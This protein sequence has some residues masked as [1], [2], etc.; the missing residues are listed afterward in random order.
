MALP[1]VHMPFEVQIPIR[2]IQRSAPWH[3][4]SSTTFEGERSMYHSFTQHLTKLHSKSLCWSWRYCMIVDSPGPCSFIFSVVSPSY[5]PVYNW[6]SA[7]YFIPERAV[8]TKATL[9]LLAIVS[10]SYASYLSV[11]CHKS[12]WSKGRDMVTSSRQGYCPVLALSAMRIYVA[13][14]IINNNSKSSRK[15]TSVRSQITHCSEKL[16]LRA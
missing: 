6:V 3:A 12:G 8:G 2:D 9:F 16:S 4:L 7:W 11:S 15:C 5:F 10:S 14:E 13:V 1:A